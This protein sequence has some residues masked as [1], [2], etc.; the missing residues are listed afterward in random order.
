MRLI[1][2]A[3]AA[4]LLSLLIALPAIAQ[5]APAGGLPGARNLRC[6]ATQTV[7]ASSAYSSGNAVGGKITCTDMALAA[8]RGGIIQ[9]VIVRDKAGQNVPYD[10]FVLD[11]D[12]SATTV[13]DKSAVAINTADLAKVIGVVQTSGTILGAASTMGVSPAAG[14]GLAYKLS[15]GTSLYF[16]LVTRGAPT[17]AS[18]SD[19][20]LSIVALPD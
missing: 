8:G 7:T 16:I 11:A 19:V 18:T 10:L 4:A 5:T 1:Q 2:R 6:D 20:T 12:P 15:S 13:T 14:L 3:A 17:Y 9:S